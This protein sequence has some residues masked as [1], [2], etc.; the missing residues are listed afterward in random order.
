ML[1]AL[2]E[3]TIYMEVRPAMKASSIPRPPRWSLVIG[4]IWCFQ[5][6]SWMNCSPSIALGLS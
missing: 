2:L 4:A 5:R 3:A 1:A 6:R